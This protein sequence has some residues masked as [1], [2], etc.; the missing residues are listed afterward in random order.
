[1]PRII[2]IPL[3]LALAGCTTMAD[4]R[5]Q[6]PDLVISSS[7]APKYFAG[8]VFDAWNEVRIGGT[9]QPARMAHRGDVI[10]VMSGSAGPGAPEL[11]DITAA[12]GGSTARLYARNFGSY[13][14]NEYVEATTACAAAD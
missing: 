11:V 14:F 6:P 9:P 5:A 10:T 3:L 12:A 2:L 13:R 7:R 4:M 1:M 8:C